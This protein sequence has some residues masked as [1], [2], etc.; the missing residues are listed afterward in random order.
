MPAKRTRLD[1]FISARLITNRR[2]VK[3]MLAQGRVLVDGQP[4]TDVQQL[5]DEFN[6]VTVDG[7]NLES[8]KPTYIMLHKPIGVVSATKDSK[9]KTVIDLLDREDKEDFHI[10][11][12]LD[13]NT[14]GLV[15]LTN[16]GL[17]SR[18]LTS[19]NNKVPK[20]YSVTV[21]NPLTEAY[22]PAF[23]EG[24]YFAFENITTRPAEIK[25]LTEF[26]AEVTLVEGKYHQIKRMFGRFR[27]QVLALHRHSIGHIHLDPSLQPG[28]SRELTTA[29]I[30]N[31]NHADKR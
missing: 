1:R 8:K 29:E 24:M 30:L 31:Q 4:A 2:N 16:D 28:E 27:N 14:S 19:P 18:Q 23:K 22:I 21:K 26:E 5:V 10:V 7:K 17:W 12:R 20:C 15:L 13:L 3:L 25:I 11:G 6:Q 9:H